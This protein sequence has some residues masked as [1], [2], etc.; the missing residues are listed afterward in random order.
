MTS[1]EKKKLLQDS[2]EVNTEVSIES[3][4]LALE[5][6]GD[7]KTSYRDYMVTEPIDADAELNR[8]SDADYDL[9]AALLTM[10]LREDYF[11][12]GAFEERY[13]NG[14]VTPIVEKMIS[15]L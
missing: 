4:Y 2:T 13:C 9:C 8:L 14:E 3:Y 1:K 5:E 10:L 7:L 11:S 15:L 12:N 6:M